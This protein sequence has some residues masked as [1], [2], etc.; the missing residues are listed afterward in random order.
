MNQ[1][2]YKLGHCEELAVAEFSSLC[3]KAKINIKYGWLIS[4]TEINVNISGGLV[5]SG[6]IVDQITIDEN[7]KENLFN[8]LYEYITA[9][10]ADLKK[11]GIS[12]SKE[13]AKDVLPLAKK[14]GSKKIN[15]LMDK[16]PNYGNWKGLKNW[17]LVEKI[18]NRLLVIKL[19]SYSDQQFW[20]QLDSFLPNSDMKRGIINLK[21]A[22]S[23]LNLTDNKKVYDP[24]CGL[25]RLA[26]AGI[27]IKDSFVLSDLDDSCLQDCEKNVEYAKSFWSRKKDF[28]GDVKYVTFAQDARMLDEVPQDLSR[29]SI[30]TE[31]YLGYRFSTSPS[32]QEIERELEIQ[33]KMWRDILN[34]C[35]EKNIKEVV[36]CLPYYQK[37]GANTLPEFIDELAEEIGYKLV[38]FS[39]ETHILYSREKTNVGHYIVKAILQK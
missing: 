24:L 16:K 22:R 27:D 36:F 37:K 14:A 19:T 25:G 4:D 26:V 7:T 34:S 28:K 35:K 15:V 30:V 29:C 20:T 9:N 11:L 2:I 33:Q 6:D 18:D 8:S 10:V 23:L 13:Y 31:G 17:I 21:L 5:Y 1:Y 3:K 39:G 38:R 12:I 32:R